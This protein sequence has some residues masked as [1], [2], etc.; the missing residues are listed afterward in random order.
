MT[1]SSKRVLYGIH[2][3]APYNPTTNEFYGILETL[4]AGQ[5][6]MT[7]ASVL[8]RGGSLKAP[9]A[10]EAGE[11]N[12]EITLT[13]R[14]YPD[15]I[16]E[17]FMGK[18]PTAVAA[19]TTG[20]VSAPAN[21]K[22]TSIVSATNGISDVAITSGKNSDLKFGLY[23]IK[24]TG[25]NSFDA[26]VS[27]NADLTRGADA[28]YQD[29]LLKVNASSLVLSATVSL[30]DFGLDFTLAGTPNFTIGDTA[31]FRVLPP[32][33]GSMSVLV[34]NVADTFPEFGAILMTQKRGNGELF[35]IDVF[36]AQGGGGSLGANEKAFSETA[37][38]ATA[39]YDSVK[40]GIARIT[41]VK[42]T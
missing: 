14:E 31:S 20:T 19:S 6:S 4:G 23:V 29:D 42:P 2:S 15:F 16:F 3:I 25:T 7:Q 37:I 36:K 10:V 39:F 11:Q 12:S 1:Q 26:Y 13:M 8:L 34:G 18:K 33:S 41:A 9:W 30:A 38:T 40:G 24:A 27:T 5:F 17:L 28:S 21:M 22:G 32:N 35:E